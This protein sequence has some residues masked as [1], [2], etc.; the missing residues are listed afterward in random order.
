M[1]LVRILIGLS[2]WDLL[3]IIKMI[4]LCYTGLKEKKK[5]KRFLG[6][7]IWASDRELT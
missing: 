7:R 4:S 2:E 6:L 1:T 5:K 3:G